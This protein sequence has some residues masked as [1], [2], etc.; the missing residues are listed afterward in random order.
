M[1]HKTYIVIHEN[2]DG[3][4]I[5]QQATSNTQH[6]IFLESKYTFV[7]YMIEECIDGDSI[8]LETED[9]VVELVQNL[10]RYMDISVVNVHIKSYYPIYNC[11][12]ELTE[13]L[14]KKLEK[15]LDIDMVDKI[16]MNIFRFASEIFQ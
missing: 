16:K 2:F 8:Y 5:D 1:Q 13:K 9:E 15:N 11:S 3:Y 6:I 4:H 7:D 10:L 14:Y 12:Y